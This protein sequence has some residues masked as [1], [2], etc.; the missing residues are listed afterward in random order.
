M[1]KLARTKKNIDN[2]SLFSRKHYE[3][4][5]NNNTYSKDSY[6][7]RNTLSRYRY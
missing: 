6:G 2:L 1:L 7:N 3:T 4:I 5:A